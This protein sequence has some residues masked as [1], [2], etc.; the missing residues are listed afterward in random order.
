MSVSANSALVQFR[1]IVV[2]IL[3]YSMLP[4]SINTLNS[5]LNST[6]IRSFVL[7][8]G[9]SIARLFIVFKYIFQRSAGQ[10][11]INHML[12]GVSQSPCQL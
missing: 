5:F 1:E 10:H 2:G 4:Y 9:Q 7:A 12:T 6:C 11:K 8:K 3:V